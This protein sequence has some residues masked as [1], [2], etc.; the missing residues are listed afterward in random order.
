MWM[1][2]AIPDRLSRKTVCRTSNVLGNRGLFAISSACGYCGCKSARFVC[3]P[4]IDFVRGMIP[5]HQA[6]K[7]RQSYSNCYAAPAKSIL[8][9]QGA[10]DMCAALDGV[11]TWSE[12]SKP[13]QIYEMFA[14][15]R[16]GQG[17]VHL[18]SWCALKTY[19]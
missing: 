18:C 2:A 14:L 12:A 3:D 4:A 9:C 17:I 13:L 7:M 8:N 19:F 10:V 1:L 5:H 6:Q 11:Q 16:D 15:V